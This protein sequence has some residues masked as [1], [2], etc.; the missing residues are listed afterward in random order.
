MQYIELGGKRI[1]TNK[2]GFVVDPRSW[3]EA[4]A[5]HMARQDGLTLSEGHWEVIS[6]L[7][8]HFAKYE[9]APMI[10]ILVKEIGKRSPERGNALYL[11]GLFPD[12]PGKQACRY[13]GLPTPVGC[14]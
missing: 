6:I 10:K 7:R 2:H 3:S 1:E 4:L 14:I 12:G 5:E 8:D 13:A 11:Y 9:I